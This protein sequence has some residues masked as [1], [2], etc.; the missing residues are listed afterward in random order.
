MSRLLYDSWSLP[1]RVIA[2]P[3]VSSLLLPSSNDLLAFLLHLLPEEGYL[4]PILRLIED[5]RET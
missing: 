5:L 3:L 4:A 2:A 1:W